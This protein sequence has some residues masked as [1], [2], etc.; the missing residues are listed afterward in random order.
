[1]LLA[2]YIKFNISMYNILK[3]CAIIVPKEN[4]HVSIFQIL[5]IETKN[6]LILFIEC[7]VYVTVWRYIRT[8]ACSKNAEVSAPRR[9]P[10]RRRRPLGV[11]QT[12]P[13]QFPAERHQSSE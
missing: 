7:D 1:M 6:Q 9:C 2:F 10:R 12:F 4:F 5:E 11:S 3:Y 13:L 8:H